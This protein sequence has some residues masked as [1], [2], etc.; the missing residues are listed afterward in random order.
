MKTVQ[1]HLWRA[2][3]LANGA[4]TIL[5]ELSAVNDLSQETTAS[6]LQ[7]TLVLVATQMDIISD[8]IDE[9]LLATAVGERGHV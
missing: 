4:A 3:R 6:I 1:D 2:K 7:N 5:N 9:Y 8:D